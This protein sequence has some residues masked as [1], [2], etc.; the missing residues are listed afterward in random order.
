MKYVTLGLIRLYQHTFSLIMPSTCR[1]TPS[2]SAY[3]YEAIERYG[4]LRGGLLTVK[5]LGRCQPFY[6]GDSY[7]PVP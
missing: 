3:G 6:H 1:F 5:R 2:C 7:D 4:V